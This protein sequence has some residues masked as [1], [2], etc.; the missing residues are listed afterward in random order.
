MAAFLAFIGPFGFGEVVLVFVIGLLLFGRDLPKVGRQLG[1]AVADLRRSFQGFRDELDRDADFR[2][3]REAFDEAR[4]GIGSARRAA[5]PRRWIEEAERTEPRRRE[6]QVEV[7]TGEPA[8][9]GDPADRSDQTPSDEAGS[10][11]GEE[12]REGRPGTGG[13]TS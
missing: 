7:T 8:P 3:A 1:R 11:D 4:H 6:P 5:D 10:D 12:T 13:V 9:E 2:A